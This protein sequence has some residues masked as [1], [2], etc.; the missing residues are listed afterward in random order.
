MT[1]IKFLW[2]PAPDPDKT[3]P[4]EDWRDKE[5]I[6]IDGN[7]TTYKGEP[8]DLDDPK[9]G[10]SNCAPAELPPGADE[11]APGPDTN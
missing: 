8:V 7:G 2:Q 5:P 3:P 10:F 9:Y 6:R 11:S 4:N 1:P